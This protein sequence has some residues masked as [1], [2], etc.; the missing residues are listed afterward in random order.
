MPPS[1]SYALFVTANSLQICEQC[2]G[3]SNI[4]TT[5]NTSTDGTTSRDHAHDDSTAAAASSSSGSN[6]NNSSNRNNS[7][8]SSSDHSTTQDP[9]GAASWP[10]PVFLPWAKAT[11]RL[12]LVCRRKHFYCY[13]EPMPRS[14]VGK[15]WR[16]KQIRSRFHL[17]NEEIL[18]L[19]RFG[20][21]L[22]GSTFCA[23]EALATAR[24]IYGGDIGVVAVDQSPTKWMDRSI[25]RVEFYHK[26][27]EGC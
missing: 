21:G 18:Q 5:D 12:C 27:C 1:V 9:M 6:N 8:N 26:R 24:V 16:K 15:R 25:S 14:M 4:I 17:R 20:C 22:G 2:F 23:E 11:I 19:K 13:P 10:L 3:K 7:S